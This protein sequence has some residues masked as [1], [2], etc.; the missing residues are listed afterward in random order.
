MK[1]LPPTPIS[2]PGDKAIKA[3]LNPT[4]GRWLYFVTTNPDTGVTKFATTY[5]EHLKN[6]AQFKHGCAKSNHC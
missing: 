3:A 1:G 5:K 4:P 6:V 2:A